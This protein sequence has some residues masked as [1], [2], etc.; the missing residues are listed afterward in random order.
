MTFQ[1]QE[2]GS[3]HMIQYINIY[4][5]LYTLII[6]LDRISRQSEPALHHILNISLEH[7]KL[8]LYSNI[9]DRSTSKNIHQYNISKTCFKSVFFLNKHI[10]KT[11]GFVSIECVQ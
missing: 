9:G 6:V 8:D 5:L 2:L 11:F 4:S 7:L 10:I 1:K 3:H